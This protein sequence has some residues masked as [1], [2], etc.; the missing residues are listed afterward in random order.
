[1]GMGL[2]A[3][4]PSFLGMPVEEILDFFL[5]VGAAEEFLDFDFTLQLHESVEHRFRTRRATGDIYVDR[6]NLVYAGHHAI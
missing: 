2:E 3:Y 1:M 6:Q 4:L 5:T